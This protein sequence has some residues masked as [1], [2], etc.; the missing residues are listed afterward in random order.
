MNKRTI[1]PLAAVTLVGSL[2]FYS[3]AKP[4]PEP[5]RTQ[6]SITYD[7]FK[8]K[9]DTIRI[10]YEKNSN[11]NSLEDA[12]ASVQ[13]L[14]SLTHNAAVLQKIE[15]TRKML[16]SGADMYKRFERHE[17]EI[18]K[19]LENQAQAIYD[20]LKNESREK[21]GFIA[22]K[23]N[24]VELVYILDKN[25]EQRLGAI[26]RIGTDN[27]T[28]TDVST[29]IGFLSNRGPSDASV[30][31]ELEQ[32]RNVLNSYF[33]MLDAQESEKK[34]PTRNKKQIE[35][36]LKNIKQNALPQVREFLQ[37]LASLGH[38]PPTEQYDTTTLAGFHHHPQAH[39]RQFRWLGANPGPS[40]A[41]LLGTLGQGPQVV[42][43][44]D[45][46]NLT[47]YV[48][49]FGKVAWSKTYECK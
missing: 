26:G 31:N 13:S 41:D 27:F 25:Q 47:V 30:A 38:T 16:A 32:T 29:I 40:P 20:K 5:P 11:I 17:D 28:R 34:R 18:K 14:R 48:A 36:E 24:K 42:L 12:I 6:E 7:Q 49:K 21:G 19:I 45:T 39:T 22:Y 23:E 2:A 33:I 8:S 15:E 3:R 44:V 4:K 46:K 37:E 43:E 35:A 9:V 10:T 1:L